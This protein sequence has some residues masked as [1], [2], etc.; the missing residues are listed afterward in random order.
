MRRSD[1]FRL[2]DT[3]AD[4]V[5]VRHR[6]RLGRRARRIT[7]DLDHTDDPSHGE[8]QTRALQWLLRQHCYLPVLATLTFNEELAQYLVASIL[9][10]GTAP[11]R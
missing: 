9:R 2:A 3:L 11:T 10:A 5:I 1:L 6:R 7:I 4:I 8:Q